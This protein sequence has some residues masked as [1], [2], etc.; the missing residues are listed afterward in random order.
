MPV[1]SVSLSE[2]SMVALDAVMKTL[3]LSNRSEAVRAS[4][5]IADSALRDGD[6]AEGHVEGVLVITHRDHGDPWLSMLQH[7]F[8]GHIKTQLHSH[9]KD[10]SCLDVMIVSADG[11]VLAEMI[12]AVHS[13][14]KADYVKFVKG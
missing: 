2:D 10:R 1:V 6:G 4:I 11:A 8:E 3:G 7:R 9:L 12:R 14:G 13:S 5:K